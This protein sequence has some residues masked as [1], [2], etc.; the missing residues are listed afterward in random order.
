MAALDCWRRNSRE[1]APSLGKLWIKF[2]TRLQTYCCLTR[3]FSPFTQVVTARQAL[4]R[5]CI[6][7]PWDGH[8][9]DN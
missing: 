7:K 3:P 9:A 2:D 8:L 5:T 1:M 4:T 6:I